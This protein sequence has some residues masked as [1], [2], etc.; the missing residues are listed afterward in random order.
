MDF[1]NMTDEIRISNFLNI[2]KDY[3]MKYVPEW[4]F[5][6]IIN[7]MQSYAMNDLYF[8]SEKELVQILHELFDNNM[9]KDEE[10]DDNR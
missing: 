1:N 6:R 9:R 10:L 4:S 2:F 8:Y 3:W 7:F 5:A